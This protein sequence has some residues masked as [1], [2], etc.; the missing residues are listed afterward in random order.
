M[1]ITAGQCSVLKLGG[2]E[3]GGSGR[4]MAESFETAVV[5]A[6]LL[7]SATA[8]HLAR[9]GARSVVLVGPGEPSGDAYT[10][11]EIFGGWFDEGRI[12][13][14]LDM[15]PVWGQL[16]AESIQRYPL[17]QQESGG[18]NFHRA[19][20]YLALGPKDGRFVRQT[21]VGL[22]LACCRVVG[23]LEVGLRLAGDG[24]RARSAGGV[25]G[26]RSGGPV[27]AAVRGPAVGVR[28]AGRVGERSGGE[29]ESAPTGGGSAS[30]RSG[31][32]ALPTPPARR[33]EHLPTQ[34]R[35]LSP[36]NQRRE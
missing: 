25:A 31:V 20:G 29:R 6:G 19:N 26:R 11:E 12:T 21:L 7:G 5:G 8:A 10:G 14:Q 4:E 35:R 32:Q 33:S 3:L 15:D 13:R 18:I 23:R 2:E 1:A 27:G 17:I 28:S 30:D 36:P 34:R 16:A 24:G 9:L 22:V